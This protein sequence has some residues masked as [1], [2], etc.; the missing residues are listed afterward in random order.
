MN[1]CLI[2]RLGLVVTAPESECECTDP[3]GPRLTIYPVPPE[4]GDNNA[5]RAEHRQQSH[6]TNKHDSTN[7]TNM[8]C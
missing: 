7:D 2:H 3:I 1:Q 5:D 6:L 4:T 8:P